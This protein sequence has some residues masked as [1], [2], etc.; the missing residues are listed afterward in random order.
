MS[1]EQQPSRGVTFFGFVKNLAEASVLLGAGLFVIGWSYLYGYYRAFGLSADS[2]NFSVD[3]VLVHSI[4]VI[5]G[6][7]FWVTSVSVVLVLLFA[8]AFRPIA[9]LVNGPVFVLLTSL[10]AG[11]LASR[12]ASGV[13]RDNALRDSYVS[14]T[15]LPYVA[16]EGEDETG[17][18]GCSLG[19]SNYRLLLRANGQ[20]FVAL[21]VDSIGKLT[22]ANMRV[23]SFP[24]TRIKALRIQIGLTQR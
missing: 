19:E 1:P 21:P 22:A 14:T 5:M 16:L 23:C 20:V 17:P 8:S 7:A 13:G 12:Y 6:T 11:L 15:T 10:V 2:L 4:P 24:E 3:S 9:R 18:T